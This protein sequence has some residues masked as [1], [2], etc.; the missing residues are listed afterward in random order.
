M[1][2]ELL[3]VYAV[4]QNDD[5]RN[6]GNPA[7][8]FTDEAKANAVADKRGWYGGKAPV[9][10]RYAIKVNGACYLLETKEPID[11]DS[12]PEDDLSNREAALSKLTPEERKLLGVY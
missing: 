12:S 10:Q 11:L 6:S 7:W 5:D 1:K 9:R 2:N 4:H 8:F 3:I